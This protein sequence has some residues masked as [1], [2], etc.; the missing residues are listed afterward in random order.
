MRCYKPVSLL[1][2]TCSPPSSPPQITGPTK[3]HII[4]ILFTSLYL[5]PLVCTCTLSKSLYS[6]QSH[7]TNCTK[8]KLPDI[9]A[10]CDLAAAST[11]PSA[12][13]SVLVASVVC[14]KTRRL[15]GLQPLCCPFPLP[16]ASLPRTSQPPGLP[17]S[18]E[19]CPSP[20]VLSHRT[21]GVSWSS[22]RSLK[23]VCQRIIRSCSAEQQRPQD[24]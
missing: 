13:L 24:T 5:T 9:K 15:L 8:S 12:T 7:Q 10:N 22:F 18:P 14:P 23:C 3:G 19:V 6:T 2:L 16:G 21:A 17:S 1:D 11:S 4:F 20:D